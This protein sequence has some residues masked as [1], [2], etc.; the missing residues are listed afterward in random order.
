MA[1][2][3]AAIL[4]VMS[5]SF[6]VIVT[7]IMADTVVFVMMIVF[8]VMV[9]V[10]FMMM[11]M[12]FMMIVMVIVVMMVVIVVMMVM[13]VVIMLLV[14]CLHLGQK[15]CHHRIR[16]LDN[17]QKLFPG[18]LINRRCNNGCLGIMLPNHGYRRFHLILI[19]NVC[20]AQDNISCIFNLIVKKFTK[21]LHIHFAFL[22]INNRYRTVQFH[23]QMNSHIPHGLHDIRKLAHAGRL[24]NYPLRMIGGNH[25]L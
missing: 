22:N 3:I 10:I 8:F 1:A 17:F 25:F 11:F 18:Q 20:P 16:L 12:S 7:V 4:V 15:I 9:I 2:A 6:V 14:L 24:D 19:G 23:I 13:M 21:I 5:M